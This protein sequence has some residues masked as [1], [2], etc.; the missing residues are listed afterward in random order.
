M[1][2]ITSNGIFQQVPSM[3]ANFVKS[4]PFDIAEVPNTDDGAL[5]EELALNEVLSM[6]SEYD[7]MEM[8]PNL[9]MVNEKMMCFQDEIFKEH[10]GNAEDSN[11][12]S[13]FSNPCSPF[14]LAT[15]P[16]EYASSPEY[17]PSPEYNPQY[18]Q[19][20]QGLQES[21]MPITSQASPQQ[22]FFQEL[23]QEQK[24]VPTSNDSCCGVPNGADQ[25]N[26]SPEDQGLYFLGMQKDQHHQNLIDDMF[27]KFLAKQQQQE[28]LL[29]HMKQLYMQL[30][31]HFQQNASPPPCCFGEVPVNFP[32]MKA[33]DS[34][35]HMACLDKENK[36]A[37]KKCKVPNNKR[38]YACPVDKCPRRF[39]RTDELKR[40]MRTHS[41]EKPFQCTICKRNFS[42]SDH[43]T[44]H[45]RTHTGE[46][47]YGCEVCGR[48]FARSDERRRHAKIHLRKPR[49]Q[50]G[51][52]KPVFARVS[53]ISA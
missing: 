45:I 31:S 34:F 36:P 14:N 5:L 48:R 8:K 1:E 24:Y 33:K 37:V 29:S 52:R 20:S 27:A 26:K 15:S 23:G 19:A 42:R 13:S 41:G 25:M 30:P 22:Y 18:V 38:P 16:A 3:P 43:L 39:S 4:E 6:Y 44:T 35:N 11:S 51:I 53:S 9:E 49:D 7:D 2:T 32:A 21:A 50:A 12:N 17:A 46:R 40:H 10:F 28:A 47:P